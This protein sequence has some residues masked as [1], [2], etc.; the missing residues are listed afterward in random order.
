M[1]AVTGVVS[2]CLDL[3]AG[4]C[5]KTADTPPGQPRR[6]A[7]WKPAFGETGSDVTLFFA[8]GKRLHQDAARGRVRKARRRG[9]PRCG[10]AGPLRTGPIPVAGRGAIAENSVDTDLDAYQT[11]VETPLPSIDASSLDLDLDL[12]VTD[13]SQLSK[14]P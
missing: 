3:A 4:Y 11:R 14:R 8:S 2:G 12:N 5:A 9:R 7:V 6:A 10:A 1:A 13:A